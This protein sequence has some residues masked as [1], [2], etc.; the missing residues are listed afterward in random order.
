MP[1]AGYKGFTFSLKPS[2]HARFKQNTLLDSQDM[3]EII[4]KFM[5]VYSRKS[6]QVRQ[7]NRLDNGRA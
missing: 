5:E 4:M 7:K 2:I 6:E 3:S 1:R